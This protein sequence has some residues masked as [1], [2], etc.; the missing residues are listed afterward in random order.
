MKQGDFTGL[1]KNYVYRVGY[2]KIV[3]DSLIS[4]LKINDDSI[5]ADVA[6]G[7]GKLTENLLKY[8]VKNVFCVEPNDDMR[9]EGAKYITDARAIWSKGSGE[10]TG[11]KSELADWVTVGSAFHWMDL[12]KTLNEFHRI[13]K[14]GGYFTAVWNPRNIRGSELHEKIE[15]KIYEMAP[16]IER[17]S[18]G[19]GKYTEDLD[20]KI[21][22]TNQ[23]HDVVYIEAKHEEKMSK[24]RYLGIWNSV[25]D[26]PAQTGPELWGKI[27]KEINEI[28]NPYKEII[29]P[30]KTR[31]WTAKV[32]K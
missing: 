30:Y 13:L 24:E 5:V 22:S 3:L 6:A 31:S 27:M 14:P 21:M 8:P 29:V 7:T 1:A 19:S 15:A 10:E 20:V 18:S 2:S 25:N 16:L 26:I 11:L 32:N 9:G 23:F 28:L 4:Y 17:K 12:S